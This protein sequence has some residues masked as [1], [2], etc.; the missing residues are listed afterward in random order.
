MIINGSM[1]DLARRFNGISKEGLAR[2]MFVSSSEVNKISRSE[3]DISTNIA[4]ALVSS[5]GFPI[6]FFR[7]AGSFYDEHK[8]SAYTLKFKDSNFERIEAIANIYRFSL[9]RMLLLTQLKARTDPFLTEPWGMNDIDWGVRAGRRLRNEWLREDDQSLDIG[10]SIEDC[11]IILIETDF[12]SRDLAAAHFGYT[13]LPAII[14]C[15]SRVSRSRKIR[16]VT[17]ELGCILR[18]SIDECYAVDS[19]VE[20]ILGDEKGIDFSLS[21]LRAI[22]ALFM[23][24]LNYS[25]MALVESIKLGVNHAANLYSNYLPQSALVRK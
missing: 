2:K 10:M 25:G 9:K 1:V 24:E 16:A 7:R 19:F 4:A 13:D 5:T 22:T 14:F 21:A 17:A 15:N 18:G 20:T 8:L 6:E 11:G 23:D 12:H 3:I